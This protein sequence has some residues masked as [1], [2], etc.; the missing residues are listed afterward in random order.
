MPRMLFAGKA[1]RPRPPV[2]RPVERLDAQPLAA[3]PV[4]EPNTDPVRRRRLIECLLERAGV[5]IKP[6]C[7]KCGQ[8]Y[9]VERPPHDPDQSAFCPD[10]KPRADRAPNAGTGCD[11]GAPAVVIVYLTL[12]HPDTRRLPARQAFPLCELCAIDELLAHLRRRT[13]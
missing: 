3:L 11:C 13:A 1:Q 4:S 9:L 2:R 5:E 6:G 8:P 12:H 7:R 10:C